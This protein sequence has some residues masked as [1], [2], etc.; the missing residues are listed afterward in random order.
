MGEG[1]N[2]LL[3]VLLTLS[4]LLKYAIVKVL[5]VLFVVSPCVKL[6]ELLLLHY[7]QESHRLDVNLITLLVLLSL[8]LKSAHVV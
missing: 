4:I 1:R 2:I 5:N 7:M 8:L 3:L 6:V